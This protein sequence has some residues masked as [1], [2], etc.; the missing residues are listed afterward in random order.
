MDGDLAPLVELTDLA[1]RRG[2]MLLMDEAHA[3]GVFGRRGR[4]VAEHLGVDE[5][6][7]A[8]GVRVGTL[9]KALGCGGGFVAG[10]RTLVEWLLNRARSYI[11]STAAP[12]A[13]A[14]AALAA[15]DIVAA[16]PQRGVELFARAAS[17]R[18]ALAAQGWDVGR[19]QSQIIPLL[20]GEPAR[21]V[22][23]SARLRN[24]GLLVPAIRPPTV[25]EGESVCVSV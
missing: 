15:L 1:G 10:S 23:L 2:A 18:D 17:L 25:P 19:S 11:Y 22:E 7:R 3:T 24:R 16:E 13:T 4:G 6:R 20:V 5:R 8:S 9:S 21:A 12:A 14:A